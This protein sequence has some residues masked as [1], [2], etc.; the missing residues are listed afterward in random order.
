M[1]REIERNKACGYVCVYT[2]SKIF[3][4][5]SASLLMEPK[6]SDEWEADLVVKEVGGK[7]SQLLH[8]FPYQVN[9][10]FSSVQFSHSVMSGSL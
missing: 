10:R 4:P 3:A 9:I 2:A 8:S 7:G 1:K 5:T 6:F